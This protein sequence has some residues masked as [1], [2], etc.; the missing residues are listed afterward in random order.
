MVEMNIGMK[1]NV[2]VVKVSECVNRWGKVTIPQYLRS[3]IEPETETKVYLNFLPNVIEKVFD[4]TE[5][6]LDFDDIVAKIKD[7]ALDILDNKFDTRVKVGSSEQKIKLFG[8][9]NH[10][11]EQE[12]VVFTVTTLY[13]N[14][15]YR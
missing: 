8:Y 12:A 13:L 5:Y 9:L 6:V 10:T 1:S 15:E 2:T 3:F 14:G 11:D 4:Y 7:E